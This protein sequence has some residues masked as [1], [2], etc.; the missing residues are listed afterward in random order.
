MECVRHVS[1]RRNTTL[2][3]IPDKLLSES[4]Q[5]LIS[6]ATVCLGNPN[7]KFIDMVKAKKGVLKS[8]SGKQTG[9]IIN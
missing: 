9:A 8:T 2:S 5:S 3:Q 7:K 4:L 1:C 6:V